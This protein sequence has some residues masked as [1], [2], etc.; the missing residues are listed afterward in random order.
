[1]ITHV[2]R[3]ANK[4]LSKEYAK[5]GNDIVIGEQCNSNLKIFSV[6]TVQRED[7]ILALVI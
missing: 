6:T 4:C 1:M 7:Q 3:D 5:N 2:S